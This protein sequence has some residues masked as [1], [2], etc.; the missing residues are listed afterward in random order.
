MYRVIGIRERLTV[1]DNE[2]SGNATPTADPD[3]DLANL[4]LDC[5]FG[6]QTSVAAARRRV[7]RQKSLQAL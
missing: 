3:H 1:G 2:T 7:P 4:R 6:V 5:I